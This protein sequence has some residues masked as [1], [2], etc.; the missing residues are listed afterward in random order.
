M[1]AERQNIVVITLDALRSDKVGAYGN[2]HDLTPNIDNFADKSTV[3]LN[4]YSNGPK[5]KASFPSIFTS[6][7]PFHNGKYADINDRTSFVEILNQEGYF[8]AGYTRNPWV[9]PEYGYDKGFENYNYTEDNTW[10]RK[11]KDKIKGID[12]PVV[13][14]IVRFYRGRQSTSSEEKVENQSEAAEF[15]KNVKKEKGDKPLFAWIHSHATHTPYLSSSEILESI[16]KEE[17]IEYNDQEK[18]TDLEE[19]PVAEEDRS[20]IEGLYDGGVR[21]ADQ[22]VGE[23]VDQIDLENTIVVVHADHGEELFEHGSRGH[24]KLYDE[25][26]SVPLIVHSPNKEHGKKDT[27]VQLADLPVTILE[28]TGCNIPEEYIGKNLFEI[29]TDRPIVSQRAES[30]SGQYKDDTQ[31]FKVALQEDGYKYMYSTAGENELYDME[32][33]PEEKDNLINKKKDKAEELNQK[34]E[35]LGAIPEGG[36][37][38][39]EVPSEQVKEKLEHLGYL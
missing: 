12:H 30:P 38:E 9:R 1:T 28:E 4:A 14:K 27:S 25:T 7:L 23:L 17:L 32:K 11:L 8:T 10:F 19:P 13:D 18:Y 2:D 6:T 20:K 15:L 3:F 36:E 31:H 24:H 39:P 37:V 21:L 5:S 33:D 22:L 35:D 16:G 26:L 34:L 29:D